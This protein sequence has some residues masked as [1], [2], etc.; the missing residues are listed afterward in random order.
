[1]KNIQYIFALAIFAL[2]ASCGDD[3]SHDESNAKQK[4][5]EIHES[6]SEGAKV[7]R[8]KLAGVFSETQPTDTLFTQLVSLDLRLQE[9]SKTLVK[10]PGMECNHAAGEHH[11]HDH[12]AEAALEELS[13]EELLELQEAIRAKLDELISDFEV[14]TSK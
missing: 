4:A 8:G 1:M 5:I 2:L 11:H 3:H 12:A 14:L 13:D 7:F 6:C 9:W 10:L